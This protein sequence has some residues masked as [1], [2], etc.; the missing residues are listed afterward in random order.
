MEQAEHDE[1]ELKD[2]ARTLTRM[3]PTTT[4]RGIESPSCDDQK[5]PSWSTFNSLVGLSTEHIEEHS[6]GFLP[7]VPHPAMHH[8][9]VFTD[10]DKLLDIIIIVSTG[11]NK[12]DCHIILHAKSNW[13][14][15]TN[16]RTW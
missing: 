1:V 4:E 10:V 7:V 13:Y 12:L 14:T 6:V 2:I 3:N 15:R 11:P 16:S 9:T 5:M 8:A